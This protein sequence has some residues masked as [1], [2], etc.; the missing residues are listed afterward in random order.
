ME[1]HE[2]ADILLSHGVRVTQQRI[3]VYQY[4]LTHRTHPSA[5]TIYSALVKEYPV[6]SRTTIYN[7]LNALL[8]AHLIRVVTIHA[9]EQRFDAD[10]SDHGHFRCIKC[11]KI[12]D[13]RVN[14]EQI[15]SL[16]PDGF[17]GEQGDVYFTGTCPD[18]SK[19]R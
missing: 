9:D 8:R 2:L 17:H 1:D 19:P 10:V 11:G 16:C 15:Y 4:L 6:F 3:A 14:S 12:F 5:D 18:C 13:F 7:S